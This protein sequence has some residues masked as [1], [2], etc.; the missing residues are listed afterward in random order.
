VCTR[1]ENILYKYTTI[2]PG[3][4]INVFFFKYIDALVAVVLVAAAVNVK[5][6]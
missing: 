4:D 5:V 2:V 3:F 1:W 6:V